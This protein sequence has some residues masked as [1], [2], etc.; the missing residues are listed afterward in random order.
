MHFSFYYKPY[1][2]LVVKK[3]LP[4]HVWTVVES[5]DFFR[6]NKCPHYNILSITENKP[7]FYFANVWAR[8]VTEESANIGVGEFY[9]ALEKDH[10]DVCK[11]VSTNCIIYKK[12]FEAITN[13][14]LDIDCENC[15]LELELI[16]KRYEKSVF[17]LFAH[18][19]NF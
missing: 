16:K 18:F 15:K 5:L 2:A 13:P 10:L 3:N 14:F 11:P 7:T 9:V 12:I 17:Q 6:R 8:T 1:L 19:N 4:A